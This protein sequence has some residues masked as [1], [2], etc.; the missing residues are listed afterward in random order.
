MN[1]F[2]RYLELHEIDPISL[3][4]EAKEM[5]RAKSRRGEI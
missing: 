1:D 2:Q 4:V 3:S 5:H